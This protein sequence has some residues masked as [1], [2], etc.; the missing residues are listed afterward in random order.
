MVEQYSDDPSSKG[1]GGDFGIIKPNSSFPENL[2]KVVFA[3]RANDVA[4][5]VK[6]GNAFY[7]IRLEEKV[8]PPIDEVRSE[9]VQNIRQEHLDGFMKALTDRFR[10]QVKNPDFFARPG[11]FVGA[12]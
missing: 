11:A 5:P 10:P 8:M 1:A 4:D 7:V 12:R 6:S 3:M 2:R 9:I